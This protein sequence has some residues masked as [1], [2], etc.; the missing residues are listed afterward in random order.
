MQ[1]CPMMLGLLWESLYLSYQ[2]PAAQLRYEDTT[3]KK[4][5]V[6]TCSLLH[7]ACA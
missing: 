1:L 3:Y 2:V 7:A 5:Q 6:C 4:E